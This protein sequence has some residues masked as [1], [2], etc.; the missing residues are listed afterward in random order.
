[1]HIDTQKITA[2]IPK[3][4]LAKAQKITKAGITETIK[5][6]LERL[7]RDKI[8][9]ETLALKGKYHIS[10]DIEKLREDR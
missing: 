9:Q 2:H 4:L 6:G 10:L 3:A 1:M 8:Y 7:Q 5:A